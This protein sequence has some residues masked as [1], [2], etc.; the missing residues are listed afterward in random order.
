MFMRLFC[1][2]L[3]FCFVTL[4]EAHAASPSPATAIPFEYCEGLL[5][6][7]VQVPQSARPLN[8]ILDTGADVSV[9]N[10]GTAK[11]LGLKIGSRI[12][13][14][15]VHA[16]M[17]GHWPARLTAKAGDLILPSKYLAL[18]LS[19]LA[20]SCGRPLD[21]LLGADFI[22]GRL[23]QIDF[24]SRQIRFPDEVS[25]SASDTVVPLKLS[26]KSICVS[27]GINGR[28]RQWVR[29]DTG[30]ATALQWVTADTKRLRQSDKP[31]VG[32][33][34]L[35]IPQTETTVLLGA[36]RFDR[37]LTG[38]HHTAIFPD[39]AGLLGNALLSRFKTA[40]IDTKSARLVLGPI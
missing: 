37:V 35:A 2:A 9:I 30:C 12:N 22:R 25:P 1:G 20:Q 26:G 3:W 17:T 31:A 15:G 23:V 34:K 19:K 24:A 36:T 10:A 21:G 38:I 18:D 28:E 33:T 27:I 6:V 32:L 5:W 39:E 14:Q 16:A 40:T 8:F 7:Q 13:V 11:A 29:L 4:G